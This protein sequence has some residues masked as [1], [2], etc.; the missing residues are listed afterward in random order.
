MAEQVATRETGLW[1]EEVIIRDLEF[2]ATE[3]WKPQTQSARAATFV[4][5][6]P[7]PWGLIV[8]TILGLFLFFIPGVIMYILVVRR[9]IRFQNLVVTASPTTRGSQVTVRY[10][11]LAKKLV[12]RY[13][14]VLPPA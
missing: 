8:L 6:P 14:N 4:G 12:N 7:I 9:L 10:P 13:L 11:G 3:K 2:F 5:R 1:A